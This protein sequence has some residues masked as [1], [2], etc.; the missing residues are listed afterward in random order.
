MAEMKQ[1]GA[2]KMLPPKPGVCQECAVDHKP[3]QPHNQQSLY[4]QMAFFAD[5][6][7]YPTWKDAMAHC[8]PE[9]QEK[10]IIALKEKGVKIE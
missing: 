4:Y 7:R 8:T 5:H 10:W 1:V 6:N 2:F 9:L 3:D